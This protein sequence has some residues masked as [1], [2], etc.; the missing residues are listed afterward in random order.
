M[1]VKEIFTDYEYHELDRDTEIEIGAEFD[2]ETGFVEGVALNNPVF[3]S[4]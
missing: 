1:S 3:L 2:P 4:D